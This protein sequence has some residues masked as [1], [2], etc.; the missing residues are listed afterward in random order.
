MGLVPNEVQ[1]K[2]AV[3]TYKEYFPHV[4]GFK[5]YAGPSVGDLTVSKE[6]EQFF[7]YKTLA[8][9]DYRGVL[10]VH[11]EKESELKNAWDP[12]RPISHTEARPPE[13][14]IE[15]VAEQIAFASQAG[16]KGHLHIT[17]VSD[18]RTVDLVDYAKG[19]YN[20]NISCAV[21]P[22]HC[23]LDKTIMEGENG[24]FYV[25][26]PPLNTKEA[27]DKLLEYL[28]EG[29]I[30]FTS[31]DHAPHTLEEKLEGKP[32]LPNL[33]FWPYYVNI[34]KEKGF[35]DKRI[36]EVTF[37]NVIKI[38]GLEKYIQPKEVKA[39]FNLAKEYPFKSKTPFDPYQHLKK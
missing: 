19:K 10:V 26:N 23:L 16:F 8:Q 12:E 21:T 13:A 32:G 31:S 15:S 22:H 30:D 27:A 33:P 6:E 25:M 11:C 7:I 34:L 17:H 9:L 1:I 29:K 36:K 37:G 39:M 3:E 5:M 28:K 38:Y 4:V 24:I 14:E 20:M 35:S 18:P 2:E